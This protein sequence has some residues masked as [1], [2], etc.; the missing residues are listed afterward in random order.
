MHG[1]E[2]PRLPDGQEA[3]GERAAP[4]AGRQGIERLRRP[5]RRALLVAE[6]PEPGAV[7]QDDGPRRALA[8]ERILAV[9]EEDEAPVD[10]PAEEVADRG[11]LGR[12]A[13][14]PGAA[15]PFEF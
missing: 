13:R 4:Q 5:E 9:P 2:G 8:V 7:P 1:G 14:V 3:P 12:E 11:R 10:E 15:E 6:E